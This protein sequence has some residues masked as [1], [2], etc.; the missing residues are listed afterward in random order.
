MIHRPA[1]VAGAAVHLD[2]GH[3]RSNLG[4][5]VAHRLAIKAAKSLG[6]SRPRELKKGIE[7]V[8]TEFGQFPN[9]L[10]CAT[11]FVDQIAAELVND[12]NTNNRSE[13]GVLQLH[14]SVLHGT[15]LTLALFE[16]VF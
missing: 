8:E 4:R 5:D 14:L 15:S 12:S 6:F 13:H 2:M 9:G 16:I 1:V 3:K 10:A 11:A 7:Y